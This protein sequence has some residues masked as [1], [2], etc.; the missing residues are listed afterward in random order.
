M[1]ISVTICIKGDKYIRCSPKNVLPILSRVAKYNVLYI[2]IK[3]Y[4]KKKDNM[5]HPSKNAFS[6]SLT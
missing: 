6:Y 1:S 5:F 3:S 2:Y 4:L